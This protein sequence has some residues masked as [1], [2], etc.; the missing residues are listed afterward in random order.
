MTEFYTLQQDTLAYQLQR[1]GH[2]AV[3]V[4]GTLLSG[5][6]PVV[7][8]LLENPDMGSVIPGCNADRM[9]D[10]QMEALRFYAGQ[11]LISVLRRKLHALAPLGECTAAVNLMNALLAVQTVRMFSYLLLIC[12]RETRHAHNKRSEI[13]HMVEDPHPSMVDMI[14]MLMS[15]SGSDE[16]VSAFFKAAEKMPDVTLGMYSKA[17]EAVFYKGDFAS[18]FGGKKWGLI[19]TT[20]R[21]YVFGELSPALMLDTAFTLT[22][23]TAPIFNKGMFYSEY[24]AQLA[25]ILDVQRSG[26]IPAYLSQHKGSLDPHTGQMLEIY[27]AALPDVFCGY[28]DYY[29]VEKLGANKSYTSAKAAQVAAHGMPAWVAAPGSPGSKALPVPDVSSLPDKGEWVVLYPGCSV[30][31][32]DHERV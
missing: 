15:K 31:K 8:R 12:T 26:Q 18:A 2:K 16:A 28:V 7:R 5:V 4:A 29:L 30:M 14:C 22:H 6:V 25:T 13:V 17:M 9:A 3:S 32:V 19:A 23:N 1:P 11:H 21:R 10:P 27:Q 24:T 20:L